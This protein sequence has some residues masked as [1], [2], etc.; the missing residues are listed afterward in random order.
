MLVL[1]MEFSRGTD[2]AGGWTARVSGQARGPALRPD[3]ALPRERRLDEPCSHRGQ[4][5]RKTE[6]RSRGSR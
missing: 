2:D 4:C 5:P 1:A 6:Q 3:V